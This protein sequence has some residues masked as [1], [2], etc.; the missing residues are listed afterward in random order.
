MV[1]NELSS[2][3]LL[4]WNTNGITNNINELQI[5]L[6]ENNVDIGLITESHLT[7]NSKFK[8]LGYKCLQANHP[9]YTAHAGAA[10]LISTKIPLSHFTPKSNQHM[11][12][13]ATSIN[14][15]S[16]PTSIVSAYF[17]PGCHFPTENFSLYFQSLN[18]TYTIGDDFNAKHKAWGCRSNNS[19]GHALFNF[20][21]SKRSKI[22]SPPSPTYWPT[23]AN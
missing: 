23:H 8:I 22:I 3:T 6:K 10:L 19:R 14:I 21:T 9:D 11:Q 1:A 12:L 17:Q 20:I 7:S 18:H 5:A 16:I 13:V 2:L 15:N 4:L